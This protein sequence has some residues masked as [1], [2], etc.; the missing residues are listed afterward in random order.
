MPANKCFHSD[1]K[2]PQRVKQLL[3]EHKNINS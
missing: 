1:G 3:A 2:K